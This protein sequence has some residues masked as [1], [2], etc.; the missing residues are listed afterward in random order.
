[1]GKE[2]ELKYHMDSCAQMETV[3]ASELIRPL[4]ASPWQT[5]CMQTHYYDLASRELAR[6]KWTLRHRREGEAQVICLKTPAGQKNAR[7]EYE[8]LHDRIDE[9]AL[10]KLEAIGAPL[11]LRSLLAAG[12]LQC[13]CAAEFT[14]RVAELRLPDGTVTALSGD[15]GFLCGTRQRL[16]FCEM[17]MEFVR[18]SEEEMLH[19]GKRLQTELQLTI[20]PLSK[21]ARAAMLK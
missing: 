3:F 8:V 7:C 16:P 10:D 21:F 14:R 9:A 15:V 4:L 5:I 19:F 20:E 12:T 2:L 13:V 18:G 6:R 11:T 17:E 1:M